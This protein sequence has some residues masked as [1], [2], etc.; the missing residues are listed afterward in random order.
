MKK[1]HHP[2][3]FSILLLL[4]AACAGNVEKEIPVSSVSL[5]VPEIELIEGDTYLLIATVFPDN[6]TNK[7]VTWAS[8]SPGI[9]FISQEGVLSA[10]SKGIAMITATAETQSAS[11]KI[12][13]KERVFPVESIQLNAETLSLKPGESA[14]LTAS[15][16][17]ENASNKT[18]LWTSSNPLV[19]TVSDGD[20]VALSVGTT[21]ITAKAGDETATC[22]VTV[23]PIEVNAITISPEVLTLRVGESDVLTATVLPENAADKKVTWATSN[24]NVAT[25]TEGTVHAMNAGNATITASAGAKSATCNV[26]VLEIPV[27]SVS[28][29]KTTLFMYIGNKET[30][31]ASISPEN[32]TN[33]T[34]TWSS[35]DPGVASV[36]DGVITAIK[37][38]ATTITA[39][40]GGQ[41]ATCRVSVI[42]IPVESVTLDKSSVTVYEGARFNLF[43]TVLPD[44]AADKTVVWTSSDE[45]IV[46]FHANP[47]QFRAVSAGEADIIATSGEETAICHVLVKESEAYSLQY[48][49]SDGAPMKC[50]FIEDGSIGTP[51]KM[52][53]M[54]I[55][56]N[57]Y[58]NG[59]GTLTFDKPLRSIPS[60]AFRYCYNLSYLRIPEGVTWIDGYAFFDHCPALL[61]IIFPNSLTNISIFALSM[62]HGR[63]IIPKNVVRMGDFQFHAE[64]LVLYPETPPVI[65]IPSEDVSNIGRVYVPDQSLDAYKQAEGW[66]FLKSRIFPISHNPS[67][68]EEIYLE[69]M[70]H[71]WQ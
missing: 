65:E 44:N 4:L 2:I 13:V 11:C 9:A 26:T 40:V 55:V 23:T 10:L 24:S 6:A 45:S 8:N 57:V 7:Q 22:V 69:T 3:V 60:N 43:A 67:I 21:T 27:S 17:P 12:T 46:K 5:S 39:A 64:T 37:Y 20:V 33:K 32:A 16:L 63:L 58:E 53:N 56:S 30:L 68:G 42:P 47:S 34:V 51:N 52:G 49:T 28:L 48:A 29:N 18:V 41:A 71:F 35:S 62:F 59:V 70:K 54:N 1:N 36:S 38:G 25:V 15:V 50:T 31:T 66:R 19:A 61:G 14:L